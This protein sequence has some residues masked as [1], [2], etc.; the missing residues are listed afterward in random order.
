MGQKL[1]KSYN[2]KIKHIITI[3]GLLILTAL[4]I[5]YTFITKTQFR[6]DTL[7]SII[8]VGIFYLLYNKLHQDNISYFFFVSTL[9]LHNLS[10]YAINP[11]G[12]RFDHYM[13][14][15]SGFTIALIADRSFYEKLSNQKRFLLVIVFA[16]GIGAIGE[17][18]EWLGYAILGKGEGFF[19]YG[20]GDEGEWNNAVFDIIFNL[21][22]ATTFAVSKLLRK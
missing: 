1:L 22:G 4:L 7:G 12:I 2:K 14:F 13:H 18:F 15:A 8:L 6:Y 11:L 20:V 9:I 3:L 17:I 10:L 5:K 19:F 21:F 16:V